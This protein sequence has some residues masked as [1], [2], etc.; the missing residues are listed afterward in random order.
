MD[1][2]CVSAT[3]CYG[4]GNATGGVTNVVTITNGVPGALNPVQPTLMTPTR[5]NTSSA[6]APPP[7]TPWALGPKVFWRPSSTAFP[8]APQLVPGTSLL[9]GLACSSS[10]TCYATGLSD[11]FFSAVVVPVTNGVAGAPTTTGTLSLGPL[12]CSSSTCV[13][14]GFNIETNESVMVHIVDGT[15]GEPLVIPSLSYSAIS[16]AS[17]ATCVVVGEDNPNQIGAFVLIH[18]P[19]S[20]ADA[21]KDGRWKSF[22]IPAFK[23]QGACVSHVTASPKATK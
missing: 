19:P 11:D 1:A 5:S 16:C 20:S 22:R 9:F 14:V 2:A 18:Q 15:I 10:S 12:T 13:A 4:L 23:N 8:G 6:S 17:A 7:A 21:C 3:T